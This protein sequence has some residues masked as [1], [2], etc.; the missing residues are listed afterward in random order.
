MAYDPGIQEYVDRMRKALGEM[1][2][3]RNLTLAQRRARADRQAAIINEPYPA[4]LAVSDT[5]IVLP[6]REIPVRVYRP[7]ADG[8][9]PTIV[10]LH[11][12]AFVAGSPQG[13]D[14]IT[15]SLACNTGAQV[16]SVHYRRA[17][18]NPYPA[19]TEDAY[20]AL[21]WAARET[22]LL[23]VD[24][25]RIAVAGDSAGGNLAAACT[26]LARDRGGPR[27]CMQALIYPTLDADL[28]TPS[29]LHNTQDAF[30]T[31]EAM[32]FALE[33]FLP[34]A[35]TGRDEGYALPMRAADHAGLPP[36][37]LILADHDPLLDDGRRYAEKLRA[38]GNAVEMHIGQGMIHGFLRARRMSA[39]A[40]RE[41]H[42]LCAALRRALSLPEP[43]RPW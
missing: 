17:P 39:V 31:R 3:T 13:H 29:Y 15:A 19:P 7:R 9:L 8:P 26:L 42:R 33:S 10:Y 37:C 1:G 20:E 43:A 5:Y 41:F 28:D 21:T 23:G 30:L 35:M 38:A 25:D 36:A 40:D 14:F 4:W 34:R 27:L 11:G 12:G 18:E 24:P 22:G 6:G 16:L 32:A 2:D